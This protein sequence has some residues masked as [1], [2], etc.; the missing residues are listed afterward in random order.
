MMMNKTLAICLL[1]MLC[2]TPSS[3]LMARGKKRASCIVFSKKELK[4]LE[5]SQ[6]EGWELV[7]YDEF[8]GKKLSDEWTRIPRYPILPNGTNS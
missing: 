7:W 8:D 6:R 4:F 2:A 5:S 3:D 1:A